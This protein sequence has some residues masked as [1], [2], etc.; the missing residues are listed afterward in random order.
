MFKQKSRQKTI[1]KIS[2]FPQKYKIISA[3]LNNSGVDTTAQKK[4]RGLNILIK[5]ILVV[6][7][8]FFFTLSLSDSHQKVCV[9]I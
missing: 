4:S 6:G 5:R 7:F 1:T 9:C 3:I 2:P 8:G